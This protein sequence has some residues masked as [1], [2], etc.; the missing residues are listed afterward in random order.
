M[1]Y[2]G[3]ILIRSIDRYPG[4]LE[5]IKNRFIL[6]SKSTADFTERVLEFK[7][8]TDFY[9]SCFADYQI[10][11]QSEIQKNLFSDLESLLLL[12]LFSGFDKFD[13]IAR[14][15]LLILPDLERC[16]KLIK[17]IHSLRSDWNLDRYHDLENCLKDIINLHDL[18]NI[19]LI[20]RGESGRLAKDIDYEKLNPPKYIKDKLDIFAKNKTTKEL[21]LKFYHA[22]GNSEIEIN[23][24]G[25]KHNFVCTNI[26]ASILVYL[27]GKDCNFQELQSVLQ[28]DKNILAQHL[29][30]LAHPKVG[31]VL[32]K[33][34][35]GY[36]EDEH[37]LKLAK[38]C[39]YRS[40]NIPLL[41]GPE[42]YYKQDFWT[43]YK[44]QS[45]IHYLIKTRRVLKYV[46]LLALLLKEYH[47]LPPKLRIQKELEH[48]IET[49]Y[50]EKD[51]DYYK[52]L[53]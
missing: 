7:A 26:Q 21:K 52:Y 45:R 30:S 44:L 39:K 8:D 16:N 18:G 50:I 32:K 22:L 10:Q 14:V 2:L 29:L 13:Q 47:E 35:R 11:K 17:Y 34:N 25:K 36:V 4:I 31:L 24:G 49:E 41:T 6:E 43:E 15:N 33:P 3:I 40:T 37:K 42:E 51:G 5:A 28:T 23:F 20:I 46:N 19:N 27:D 38:K 9:K 1:I 12:H 48:L 53:P